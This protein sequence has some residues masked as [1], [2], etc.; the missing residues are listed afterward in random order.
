MQRMCNERLQVKPKDPY[1]GRFLSNNGYVAF[2]DRDN[3]K[4]LVGLKKLFKLRQ[5]P[6]RHMIAYASK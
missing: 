2:V 6:I 4:F 3:D 1:L 5:M